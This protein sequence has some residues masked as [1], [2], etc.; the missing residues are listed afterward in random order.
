[1]PQG[2]KPGERRGG[3]AKGTPN[4]STLSV[5]ERL[6]ELGCDPIAGMALIAMDEGSSH[7][8]RGKMFAE[9]AQYVWPKRKAIE[10]SGPSGGVIPIA[11]VDSLLNGNRDPD[12]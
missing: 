9:L 2:A 10:H 12:E 5:Q 8:L 4:K 11:L 7:E 3:R 1:M 6:R